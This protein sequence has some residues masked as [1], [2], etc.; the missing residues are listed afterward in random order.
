[1]PSTYHSGR[2][3]CYPILR[4][5]LSAGDRLAFYTDGLTEVFDQRGEML[6]VPGLQEIMSRHA[7]KPL[8]GMKQ[9]ILDDVAAWRHG[10]HTDDISLVLLEV[11]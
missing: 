6:G 8:G 7:R 11:N 10:P 5:S 4:S 2:T 1:M 3:I 9:A